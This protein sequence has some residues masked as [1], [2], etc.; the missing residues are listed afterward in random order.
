MI[1]KNLYEAP[2]VKVRVIYYEASF[3]QSNTGIPGSDDDYD[4]QGEF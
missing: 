1:K 2:D 3:L 4:D